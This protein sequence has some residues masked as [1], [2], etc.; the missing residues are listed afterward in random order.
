MVQILIGED[1]EK[2]DGGDDEHDSQLNGFIPGLGLHLNILLSRVKNSSTNY[3]RK[4]NGKQ[5]T[6]YGFVFLY[7]GA[8]DQEN[9]KGG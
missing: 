4:K 3:I 9:G 2:A 7:N 1:Q 6:I 8:P 5:D